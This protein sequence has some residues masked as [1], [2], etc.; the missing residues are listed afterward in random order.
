MLCKLGH[1]VPGFRFFDP[2]RFKQRRFE[3]FGVSVVSAERFQSWVLHGFDLGFLPVI[4]MR[5]DA[6]DVHRR[7]LVPAKQVNQHSRSPVL[8]KVRLYDH[9]VC[10]RSMFYRSLHIAVLQNEPASHHPR[11]PDTALL[12]LAALPSLNP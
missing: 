5:Q 7:H 6:Y 3:Q 4:A 10:F 2:F 1:V 8:N 12:G 9:S 11:Q